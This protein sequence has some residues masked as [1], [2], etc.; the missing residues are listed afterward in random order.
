M[1]GRELAVLLKINFTQNNAMQ[2]AIINTLNNI[3]F[4]ILLFAV[5]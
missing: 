5:P 1:L 2:I 3:N 4:I